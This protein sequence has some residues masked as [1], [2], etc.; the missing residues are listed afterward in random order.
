MC[1]ELYIME[2]LEKDFFELPTLISILNVLDS[3][4]FGCGHSRIKNE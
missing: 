4:D 2:L 1:F 3:V